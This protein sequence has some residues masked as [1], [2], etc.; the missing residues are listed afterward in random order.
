MTTR[1]IQGDCRLVMQ[2][3]EPESVDL[4]LTDPPYG[5]TS[6]AWD[7]WQSGWPAHARRVL[8]K[9]G[10]MWVFGSQRMFWNNA[11]DFIGWNLAQDLVWEKQN[12]TGFAADRFKRV[13]ELALQFYRD[14]AS[15]SD[16]Y[17]KVQRVPYFGPDKHT[18]AR[19]M[20]TPHT[21]KIGLQ[22]YKDDGTRMM[23]SVLFVR[24]E[25]G[26]A[27][28]PTQKP[29]GIVEPLL[30]YSC[31]PGGTVLDCFSGSGTTGI[32]AARHGRQSILI[33]AKQEFVE[34]TARRTSSDGFRFNQV[35]T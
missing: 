9:S 6:L 34:L 14:D 2:G 11:G 18:R 32:V 4:I 16:V 25:H 27:E 19:S 5:E 21:G 12:G 33:E 28:H 31:P 22:E 35:P 30:L 24:N 23:R 29:I 26:R 17:K 1:I 15:W 13:H 20:R 3:L 8:K 7:R 10:S